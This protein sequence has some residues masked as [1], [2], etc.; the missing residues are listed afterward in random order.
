MLVGEAIAAEAVAAH[1]DDIQVPRMFEAPRFSLGP[2]VAAH[3]STLTASPP[4][5]NLG[6]LV[7]LRLVT[8]GT[9]LPLKVSTDFAS[10]KSSACT[11]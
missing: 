6:R 10:P 2:A 8:C 9:D 3:L 7:V 5:K 1:F 11:T 4:N